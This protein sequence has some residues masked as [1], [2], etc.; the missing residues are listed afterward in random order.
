MDLRSRLPARLAA[1]VLAL[2]FAT[3]GF[4]ARQVAQPDSAT[5]DNITRLTAA[6][7]GNSQLAHRP[8]D[9]TL[10]SS[11]LDRYFDALDPEHLL[12]LES[13]IAQ[14]AAHRGS[15]ARNTLRSGD[16]HVAHAV[17]ERFLERLRERAD[18]NGEVLRTATFD[19]TGDDEYALDRTGA[20]RP[21]DVA[22]ARELWRQRLRVDYLQE[23]LEDKPADEIASTLERRS[24][25]LVQIMEQMS[26]DEVLEIYLSA[27]AR[28]YDPHSD[29]LGHRQMEELAISM[30]LSLFGI[31]ARLQSVDGRCKIVDV[32]AGGPAKRSGLLGPGD[33]IVAVA[34]E[35]DEVVDVIDLPLSRIVSMI[36]GPKGTVV[37]LTVISSSD[38]DDGVRRQVRL[39]RDEIKLEEQRAS[40]T[41]VDLPVSAESTRRL[42]IIDLPSFYADLGEQ[43]GAKAG[44]GQGDAS[45]TADVARLL[46][47]LKTEHVEGIVLDLRRNGGGSLQEAIALAGLF[48]TQGPIVQTRGRGGDVDVAMD[49]DPGVIYD[50][51]LVVL[52][53]RFSASASE[54]VAGALQDYERAVIVGDAATYG[55]GTVQSIVPLGPM[56]KRAG[57]RYAYDPGAL[58]VTI[59][60]FYR[61]GGAS[62]QLKGVVADIVVPSSSGVRD[63]GESE[64][65]NPLPWD[66]VPPARYERL[67]SVRPYLAAL[68]AESA[69]RVAQ[70][71]DFRYL[72]PELK[73][74]EERQATRTV[75]LN[76]ARRREELARFE[77]RRKEYRQAIAAL[78]A[79]APVSYE[80]SVG[81]AARPGLPPPVVPDRDDAPAQ[82]A[83]NEADPADPDA[84]DLL[85]QR[86]IILTEAQRIL[87]DYVALSTGN[88]ALRKARAQAVPLARNP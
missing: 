30:N 19:F 77:A 25:R 10:A 4:A 6:V 74:L 38:G 13:D 12:F 45:A 72:R 39:V 34:Q 11:F 40:A 7:L 78:E 57:L 49:P 71:E 1:L 15:L 66:S 87:A 47:K 86:D 84:A 17:F 68:R 22:A 20:A 52:T 32:L 83:A 67:S 50:G 59:R 26:R 53:S 64:L 85:A 65:D 41:I 14:F 70:T 81:D 8:L 58:K 36:R 3:P 56:M 69:R 60:K 80:I 23:K 5:E 28:V 24:R 27:L 75:S 43:A 54:I 48:I 79:R 21:R 16:N 46:H 18:Y 61:P 37:L 55:K 82:D 31:G 63:V 29:Y 2:L 73:R 76:E 42:G 44:G 33:H 9:A 88:R 62:T 51:P 35:G